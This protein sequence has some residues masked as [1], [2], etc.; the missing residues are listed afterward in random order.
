MYNC[1][2]IVFHWCSDFIRTNLRLIFEPLL[3]DVLYHFSHMF[4]SDS[5][6]SEAPVLGSSNFSSLDSS[7][8]KCTYHPR[9]RHAAWPPVQNS[10]ITSVQIQSRPSTIQVPTSTPLLT[11]LRWVEIAS[12]IRSREH[13]CGARTQTQEGFISLISELRNWQRMFDAE[14]VSYFFSDFNAHDYGTMVHLKNSSAL[15]MKKSRQQPCRT[16]PLPVLFPY[17]YPA[18][19]SH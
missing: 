14:P 2:C 6:P 19:C 12:H 8:S 1:F 15:K 13:L 7:C 4:V 10:V 5:K 18:I 9:G 3:H 17:S 16:L 11:W